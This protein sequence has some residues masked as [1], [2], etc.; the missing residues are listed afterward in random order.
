MTARTTTRARVA[1]ALA[2][3]GALL[4]A[5]CTGDDGG[6]GNDADA[7]DAVGGGASDPGKASAPDGVMAEQ[8]I[9]TPGG[10]AGDVT[11]TLRSVEVGAE[12]MTVRWALRWD[13][14]EAAPDAEIDY[15]DMGVVP[16]TT[17]VDRS[18]LKAYKPY[19]TDGAWQ[20]D[21]S[22]VDEVVNEETTIALQQ[23][24][25]EESM[26]VSPRDRFDFDFPNHGTIE[27]WAI[28]PAPEGKPATVD[29]APAE[30]LPLFT[31]ATVTY[32]DGDE[33]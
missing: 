18:V 29:V 22:K 2:L 9:G 1:A 10:S 6:S 17:V 14:D 7:A 24:R 16:T 30:G 11:V 13:D 28:L 12:N 23:K 20:P 4:L 25:C 5:G 33:K 32:L 3:A 27:A 31:D 15:N 19:C 26:T 21:L 8:K